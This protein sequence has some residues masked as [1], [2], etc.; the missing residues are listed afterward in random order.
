MGNTSDHSFK[1]P[2]TTKIELFKAISYIII[3]V[4]LL[5]LSQV[6]KP[7]EGFSHFLE[8]TVSA[9]FEVLFLFLLGASFVKLLFMRLLTIIL[10]ISG[11]LACFCG[12]VSISDYID[13]KKRYTEYTQS[14]NKWIIKDIERVKNE[15]IKKQNL[16]NLH[17]QIK[18]EL[19][20]IENIRKKLYSHNI[21]PIQFREI[22]SIYYLY[23]FVSTSQES[24]SKAFLH[25]DL[26]AI[27]TQIDT[28]IRQNDA[29]LRNLNSLSRSINNLSKENNRVFD[30]MINIIKD[31]NSQRMQYEQMKLDS[32]N[33]LEFYAKANF[34][35]DIF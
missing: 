10:F 9:I 21:I 6:V 25:C 8:N 18:N 30:N 17:K 26:D 5:C 11:I 3:G 2:F 22:Y 35:K 1:K 32:L 14:H 28:L 24:L 12:V 27:K 4:L 16:I 7:E 19:T 13:S 29:I 20:D 15:N 31:N 34:W 33:N 23:N